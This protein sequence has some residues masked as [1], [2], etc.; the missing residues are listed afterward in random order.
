MVDISKFKAVSRLG[1]PP[2]A[3]EASP[4]LAAPE[5]APAAPNTGASTASEPWPRGVTAY[6]RPDGRSARKTHRTIQFATRVSPEWDS[7]I[8][9]I[10]ERDGLM[11][12][13]VLEKALTA[14]EA[15]LASS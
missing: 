9:E 6:T 4:N 14:Y 13:E 8:R 3:E 7:K 15:A 12:V 11:L 1:P 5:V 2:G 10:A